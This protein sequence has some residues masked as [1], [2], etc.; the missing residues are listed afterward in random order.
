MYAMK[1]SWVGQTFALASNSGPGGKK[2]RSRRSKEERKA[3]VESFIERYQKSNSGNFP[4]LN[5]THKEVGGSYYI[6]REIVREVIQENRVLGPGS[7][8]MTEVNHNSLSEGFSSNRGLYEHGNQR[9]NDD[10]ILKN[11]A[12]VVG[13]EH[14]GS[15]TSLSGNI[16]DETR[17]HQFS[18]SSEKMPENIDMQ[19][20]GE[21]ITSRSNKNIQEKESEK[22]ILGNDLPVY[23][24]ATNI[25]QLQSSVEGSTGSQVEISTREEISSGSNQPGS[26]HEECKEN[27]Q[28]EV[29]LQESTNDMTDGENKQEVKD[30]STQIEAE[31]VVETFPLR[32]LPNNIHGFDQ[33]LGESHGP[34]NYLEEEKTEEDKLNSLHEATVSTEKGSQ[35]TEL[36]T[37]PSDS[38]KGN[39]ATGDIVVT[40]KTFSA[41]GNKPINAS[42]GVQYVNHIA[43]G[44]DD[45]PKKFSPLGTATTKTRFDVHHD[46]NS[47][48]G[49]NPTLNRINLE[50]WE[51]RSRPDANPLLALVKSFITAFVKFWTE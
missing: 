30:L 49:S 41:A 9:E 26:T 46:S 38:P 44:T 48:K 28:L 17:E 16:D 35:A 12:S 23:N 42:N 7:R 20:I 22:L 18:S 32:S 10:P 21:Q 24:E 1:G 36:S 25:D 29:Q 13:Q 31:V 45:S 4:S 47:K 3:M 39:M 11:N 2:T 8:S 34:T 15:S 51:G 50:T 5:L 33:E 43:A 37:T 27:K 19:S 14:D 6:V 40:N